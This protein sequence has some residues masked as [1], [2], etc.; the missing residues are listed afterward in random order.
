LLL[1]S[2]EEQKLLEV[3]GL[4]AGAAAAG[5]TAENGLQQQHRLRER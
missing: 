3:D 2:I 1:T 4:G 5:P